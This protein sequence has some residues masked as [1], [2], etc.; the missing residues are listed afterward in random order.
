LIALENGTHGRHAQY[1]AAAEVKRARIPL[2]LKHNMVGIAL[3][4]TRW[5]HASAMLNLARRLLQVRLT[6]SVTG[7]RLASAATCALLVGRGSVR[8]L[9]ALPPRTVALHAREQL[10]IYM[11]NL[12]MRT[13][14]AALTAKVY[15]SIGAFVRH[16]VVVG[17]K[18]GNSKS[19]SLSATTG[20]V[21]RK[22]L[23]SRRP[24]MRNLAR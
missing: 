15:G 19:L 24:A 1:L 11:W 13:F 21:L 23:S 18:P 12:A 3:I 20:R 2:S 4:V 16:C 8:L 22:E 17:H 7:L 5:R 10:G 9:S 6:A 14:R